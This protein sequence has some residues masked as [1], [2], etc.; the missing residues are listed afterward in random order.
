MP[1]ARS[2][3]CTPETTEFMVL[4]PD[5]VLDDPPRRAGLVDRLEASFPGS[6]FRTAHCESLC[7]PEGQRLIITEPLIVPVMGT[8][9]D[10]SQREPMRRRPSPALL[11]E[12]MSTLFAFLAGRSALH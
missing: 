10:G 8:A 2:D 1:A 4:L 11:N 7:D 5:D 3:L 6:N 9:G 12:M